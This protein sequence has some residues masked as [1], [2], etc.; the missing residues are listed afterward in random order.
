M[1]IVYEHFEQWLDDDC[2]FFLSWYLGLLTM[3][4]SNFK[5]LDEV[6]INLMNAFHI[7]ELFKLC[8]IWTNTCIKK[9]SRSSLTKEL[10]KMTKSLNSAY[11]GVQFLARLLK[12]NSFKCWY[13]GD[14]YYPN[15]HLPVLSNQ[16][17]HINQGVKE[18]KSLH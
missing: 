2:F 9:H 8:C 5:K 18:V 17:K 7:I 13:F 11:E 6:F 12:M 1:I 3:I 16:Q 10:F 15:W 14:Q 4:K